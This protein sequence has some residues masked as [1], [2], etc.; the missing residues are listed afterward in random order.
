[1]KVIEKQEGVCASCDE[2]ITYVVMQSR[3]RRWM[4]YQCDNYGGAYP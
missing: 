2:P 3:F 1:M 4:N